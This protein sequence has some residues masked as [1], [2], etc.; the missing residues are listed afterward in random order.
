MADGG[1]KKKIEL[2]NFLE[3][4]NLKDHY[5]KLVRQNVTT[6]SHLKATSD[7][8]LREVGFSGP[9][10]D[11][12]RKKLKENFDGIKK[13]TKKKKFTKETESWKRL[14]QR[15]T[16]EKE[17]AV[18]GENM[19]VAEPHEVLIKSEHLKVGDRLGQGA[20][21]S[22]WKGVWDNSGVKV[23]VAIKM[24]SINE[25]GVLVRE[26]QSLVKMKHPNII[27]LYGISIEKQIMLVEE[28]APF[29]CLLDRLVREGYHINLE[30]IKSY[31]VQIAEGMNYL[32]RHKVV[33]R[34]LA[35][36][37]VL[38]SE[39][40]KVK[41]CDFGMARKT[42][43]TQPQ[44]LSL[45]VA[46]SKVSYPWAAMEIL[47]QKQYSTHSDVWSF[48]VTM[49]EI[50]SQGKQP[51]RGLGLVQV[52]NHLVQGNR[53]GRPKMCSQEFYEIMAKCWHPDPLQRPTFWDISTTLSQIAVPKLVSMSTVYPD[54]PEDM[55]VREGEIIYVVSRSD[56][57]DEVYG[58]SS[59]G[60]TGYCRLSN[61][62]TDLSRA[63]PVNRDLP[64][65]PREGLGKKPEDSVYDFPDDEEEDHAYEEP[66][67]YSK[68]D[69]RYNYI[70]MPED[71]RPMEQPTPHT[72]SSTLP[73]P[74]DRSGP[75]Y[76]NTDRQNPTP[77]NLPMDPYIK[78]K[79]STDDRVLDNEPDPDSEDLPAPILLPRI[80]SDSLMEPHSV[81]AHRAAKPSSRQ[82]DIEEEYTYV[83]RGQLQKY[84]VPRAGRIQPDPHEYNHLQFTTSNNRDDLSPPMRP[85]PPRQSEHVSRSD[86]V[87]DVDRQFASMHVVGEYTQMGEVDRDNTP[88]HQVLPNDD[89]RQQPVIRV[90]QPV[91]PTRMS[92][93][94]DESQIKVKISQIQEALPSIH[95]DDCRMA[96]G[97]SKWNVQDAI[98]ALKVDMLMKMQFPY[99][100]MEDCQLALQHCQHKVDRAAEWLLMKSDDIASKRV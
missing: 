70:D 60:N 53:L 78:M 40:E 80:P 76:A 29:G 5:E 9:E 15:Q 4:Y 24:I 61:T 2:Y 55:M 82:E 99:I 88:N 57:D 6:I 79:P 28:L 95:P 90:P 50:F 54:N 92:T 31:C 69:H 20:F 23:D 42:E 98:L 62:T 12:V 3:H 22:V 25:V 44:L 30:V 86:P 100:N 46:S 26:Y 47:T 8:S 10:V 16:Q 39:P 77:A 91:S 48:G 93:S 87:H 13:M 97:Q 18:E 58:L 84:D 85:S 94:I 37:N 34:D 83:N 89:Y 56:Q 81:S 32:S 17:E 27:R 52:T 1:D 68:S 74:Q 64:P 75:L 71:Q 36:R 96:L 41:I 43:E 59:G 7:A 66:G 21:S 65:Q 38:L 33:H 45:T 51:W 19:Y 35:A 72:A 11:R 63:K 49:W 67:L 73:L 14:S